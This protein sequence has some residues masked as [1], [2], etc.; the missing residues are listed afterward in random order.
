MIKN[1]LIGIVLF[2]VLISSIGSFS[3]AENI[4]DINESEIITISSVNQE[5]ECGLCNVHVE[6]GFDPKYMVKDYPHTEPVAVIRVWTEP[7]CTGEEFNSDCGVDDTDDDDDPDPWM[8]PPLSEEQISIEEREIIKTIFNNGE[9]EDEGCNLC[10]NSVKQN[11]IGVQESITMV[12]E[13]VGQTNVPAPDSIIESEQQVSEPVEA[14]SISPAEPVET[15]P[16]DDPCWANEGFDDGASVTFYPPENVFVYPEAV[17]LGCG[18]E[19]YVTVSVR[20]N[21]DVFSNGPIE[22]R[23]SAVS[24]NSFETPFVSC[25][26]M[27]ICGVGLADGYG[28]DD[29]NLPTITIGYNSIQEEDAPPILSTPISDEI[30]QITTGQSVIFD[31]SDLNNEGENAKYN[32][33]FGDGSTSNEIITAEHTYEIPGEY[34]VKLSIEENDIIL[35]EGIANVVVVDDS[36]NPVADEISNDEGTDD[37]TGD[38]LDQPDESYPEKNEYISLLDKIIQMLKDLFPRLLG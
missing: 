9:E 31:A 29:P 14:I 1:K 24:I 7:E 11:L 36:T 22:L 5:E 28:A 33:D 37:D 6:R 16:C 21:V 20:T 13:Q 12:N 38:D 3:I 17:G 30:H 35:D 19:I 18:D 23:Y 4:E 27:V 10:G 32:W 34:T 2:A 25:S 8:I 15:E 26:G